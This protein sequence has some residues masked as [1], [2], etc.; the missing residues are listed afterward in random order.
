MKSQ[1]GGLPY[2]CHVELL[3]T[4]TKKEHNARTLCWHF[5]QPPAYPLST[6]Q[7]R[8]K[9][10]F[11]QPTQPFTQDVF[12]S[13]APHSLIKLN[14]FEFSKPPGSFGHLQFCTDFYLLLRPSLFSP[15]GLFLQNSIENPLRKSPLT[16]FPSCC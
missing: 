4:S 6:L 10:E 12:F 2:T 1:S 8:R 7:R 3:F 16:S 15:T 14:Y 11:T 9:T 5:A 13:L